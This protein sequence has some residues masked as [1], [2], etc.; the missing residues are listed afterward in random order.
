MRMKSSPENIRLFQKSRPLGPQPVICHAPFK[1]LYFGTNGNVVACCLNRSHVLGHYP[2][3][4]I[5]DI[6]NGEKMENLR[7]SLKNFDL[8]AGCFHCQNRIESRNF[9][10]VEAL[11][12]DVI[13]RNKK[14]PTS[15]EFELSNECNLNC[16]MCSSEF[17]SSIERTS[18]TPLSKNEVYGDEF[19]SELQE[20]IPHL[21]KAKFLGGEPFLIPLYYKLWE[22]MIA[23]NPKCILLVQTNAT[24]LND[25]IRNLLSRGNFRI[26]IS[27]ESFRKN[28]YENI[29]RNGDFEKVMSNVRYFAGYAKEKRYPF[30]ISVCP[31]QQNWNE[32]PEI[33]GECNKLDAILYFNTVWYPSDCSLFN[34][35]PQK[36]Q[37]IIDTLR[38]AEIPGDSATA[39]KNKLH[40]ECFMNQL[41][42]WQKQKEIEYTEKEKKYSNWNHYKKTLQEKP[43]EDLVSDLKNKITIR[44]PDSQNE[45]EA[46]K[47]ILTFREVLKQF[48]DELYLKLAITKLLEYPAEIIIQ[49]L[50]N[51]NIGKLTEQAKNLIIECK[52]EES[53]LCESYLN[54]KD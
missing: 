20:F 1:N 50:T 8:S 48:E 40:F 21:T 36:L 22:K 32:I 53:E 44:L 13:P 4:K 38:Q 46:D 27:L 45:K 42:A 3:Q 30:G 15:M 23:V 6:W 28:T 12:Y 35:G 17:S 26:C 14:Y 29:R 5:S 54:L 25:R 39:R 11:L 34:L 7:Q 51:S 33:I 2:D 41:T 49:E 43:I 18:A 52:K 37:N 16:I 31:M 19:I 24:L 47:L 9:D 10:A